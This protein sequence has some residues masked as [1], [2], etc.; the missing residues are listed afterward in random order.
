MDFVELLFKLPEEL[1][2]TF[3]R[4]EAT[5][6]KL[7]CITWSITFNSV[8]LEENLMPNY[9]KIRHHDPAVANTSHTL[10]Y[11]KYLVQQDIVVKEKNKVDVEK[12][13]EILERTI[14]E[15]QFDSELKMATKDALNLTLHNSEKVQK[16]KTLKKLND[17]YRGQIL[18]KE[19]VNCY[20]NLSN[21][22]LTTT[23][24]EFLNLGTNYHIQPKYDRLHKATELEALYNQLTELEANKTISVN[25][26][27]VS[28]LAA[29]SS[30]H[31]NP[32][33]TSTV[34]P[35]LRNA[36]KS[37]KENP[38]LV[39]RKA[40][41]SSIYVL[42][43]KAEYLDKLD[44][45]LSD[46]SKFQKINRDPTLTLKQEANKLISTLNA[47]RGDIH[48]PK[49]IGDFSPGYLYGNVK[50]H[51]LNNP[52]RPIISQV[53]TPTYSLAKTINKIITPFIPSQHM[54]KSTNDFIDLLQTNNSNGIIASLDVESLFTNVPIDNTI[55][56]ILECSYSHSSLPPPKMPKEI[57][58]QML[59]LCTKKA[60]FRSP[61]GDLYLQVEG[62]AMGS[63][64][65]PTFA[66]FYMSHIEN[67]VLSNTTNAP[68]IYARYVDDIFVQV[69]NL[70]Q[71]IN[72]K[73]QFQNNS[74]LNFTFEAS[75]N[76]KLPFLDVMVDSSNSKFHT[77]VY[78]KPTSHGICL[79]ANS[80]CAERYKN[81]VVIN[82]LNRAYKVTNSWHDF[83]NEVLIMKQMLI[84]NN[85]SNSVVDRL[86]EK[87]V[88]GKLNKCISI[89]QKVNI[90][91]YY[92]A[93][94]HKN[95]KTDEKILKDIIA[96]N[97]KCSNPDEKLNVVIYYK[98]RR[99][100]NLIMRNNLTSDP[101]PLCQTNVVY[102]FSCSHPHSKAENYVGMTQTTLSRRLTMHAQTGSIYQHFITEH[103]EKPTRAQLTENTT[104]IARA[105]NRYK[106]AIK[107]ALLILDHA[108]TI[109]IQFGNF[110]NILKVHNC[111]SSNQYLNF[112]TQLI[113]CPVETTPPTLSPSYI[114]NSN[115]L[116]SSPVEIH[117]ISPPTPPTQLT[118]PLNSDNEHSPLSPTQTLSPTEPSTNFISLPSAHTQTCNPQNTGPCD[119]TVDM[120]EILRG[121]GIDTEHLNSVSLKQ[122]KW[123]NF[124]ILPPALEN[125]TDVCSSTNHAIFNSQSPT[126]S[127]R[128]KGLLRGARPAQKSSNA[129]QPENKSTNLL[130]PDSSIY[131]PARTKRKKNI[132]Q[133]DHHTIQQLD[134]H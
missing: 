108:P 88:Q 56:I 1:R 106:L 75:I 132:P 21:H 79:N 109:N 4:L 62:V 102:K 86:V 85:Y 90:P 60:P 71:L 41:K 26:K 104:I 117:T 123:N 54:L 63:P 37:L 72:L 29:E 120:D 66:N 124:Q 121:F 114:Y 130:T 40:D 35:Q 48:M 89:E 128:V 103:H 119:T 111:R 39:I 28:Q 7:I 27:L 127:Q 32:K 78:H 91:I 82:F 58:R 87:F 84:N 11:R 31:R 69:D 51:K 52:L 96:I 16:T 116:D 92:H 113:H 99:T 53:L 70:E 107:E 10:E 24:I 18:V 100:S 17:L 23:E 36:A 126:I 74:V 76:N 134:G 131:R 57:L 13:K 8:C 46:S 77:T 45:I 129:H 95:Y 122:Y 19:K 98:N 6:K 15:F 42:L 50:T 68:S 112:K 67:N 97:T 22:D 49:I 110:T 14:G 12:Q 5:E 2:K 115:V 93:Q 133:N 83:H 80:E 118:L 105:E 47:A 34:N 33:Y 20:I 55:D 101:S 9:T 43:D 59:E 38:N 25:P 64:L 30:K 73:E 44:D 81:S 61:G 125:S 65:G 94:M 3:R